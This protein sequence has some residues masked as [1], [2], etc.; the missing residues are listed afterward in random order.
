MR[1]KLVCSIVQGNSPIN[2]K[3]LK[4]GEQ[5]IGSSNHL[6]IQKSED[7]SLLTFKQ[8]QENDGGNYSCIASND[9]ESAIR[10]TLLVVNILPKWVV[11]PPNRLNAILGSKL[12][13]DCGKFEF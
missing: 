13:V 1:V 9:V 2:I 10:S 7:Y 4:N 8:V 5:L 3:W 11:E 6:S 12:I